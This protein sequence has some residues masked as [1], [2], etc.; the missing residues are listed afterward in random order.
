[1]MTI[2]M[3]SYVIT[4]MLLGIWV[5]WYTTDR[6]IIKT[7]LIDIFVEISYFIL[8]IWFFGFVIMEHLVIN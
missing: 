3:W 5:M 2:G 7:E 4:A 6:S 8:I 1:M